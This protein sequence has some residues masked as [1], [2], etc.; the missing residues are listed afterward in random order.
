MMHPRPATLVLVL[1]ILGWS[2]P[3]PASGAVELEVVAPRTDLKWSATGRRL[4]WLG[5]G[6]TVERLAVR[7][8]WTRAGVRGWL[9]SGAIEDVARGS[10]ISAVEASLHEEPG[11]AVRGGLVQGVEVERV[12]GDGN[13]VEI[14]MVGWIASEDLAAREPPAEPAADPSA[15]SSR[16][17]PPG[18]P[19]RMGRL[20]AA[21]PLRRAPEGPI[22][23]RLPEGLPVRWLETRGGWTRVSIEGWVPSGAVRA[24]GAGDLAPDV[25]AAAPPGTFAGRSVTWTLE[26]VALQ[27]AEG[28]RSDFDPDE[29]FVLARAAGTAGLYVYVVV[30][31]RLRDAFGGMAPFERFRVEGTL[32]TGRSELTGNP[33]LEAEALLR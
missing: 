25:V 9:R 24:G 14:T 31:D 10:R 15:A 4:G 13:W 12:A 28:H 3:A 17:P 5:E 22:L 7:N 16:V 2:G 11:G 23:S 20:E 18:P 8:G 6:A 19:V 1:T 26:F 32:R 27:R 30:P 29:S 33:I 21:A